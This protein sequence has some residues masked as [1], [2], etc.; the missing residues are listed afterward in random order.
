MIQALDFPGQSKFFPSFC[1]SALLLFSLFLI[2]E[3]AVKTVRVW[4]GKADYTNSELKKK[5][6][7]LV[8]FIVLYIICVER[9]GFFVSSMVFMPCCMYFF[10]QR[11]LKL[12][13]AVSL[14][15]LAFMYWL[16]VVQLNLHLPNGLL[17]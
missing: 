15:L 13:I 7:I 16:F 1:L 12:M 4:Q 10:G 2:A 14:G 6:Y 17:F 9:I 5:P 11:K 3:G 8:A